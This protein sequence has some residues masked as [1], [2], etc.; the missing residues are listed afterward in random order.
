MKRF[1]LL[2]MATVFVL[3]SCVLP[4]AIALEEEKVISQEEMNVDKQPQNNT[5]SELQSTGSGEGTGESVG[6]GT[7]KSE[8]APAS[9]G[10]SVGEG[11]P[12]SEDAPVSEGEI[13]S[14]KVQPEENV[15]SDLTEAPINEEEQNPDLLLGMPLMGVL[16]EKTYSVEIP[17]INLNSSLTATIRVTVNNFDEGDY[18][19]IDVTSDNGKKLINSKYG[20]DIG[21]DW[22][23]KD[24]LNH[25]TADMETT[26]TFTVGE[27]TSNIVGLEYT[28]SLTFT[29]TPHFDEPV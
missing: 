17:P 8:G 9:E 13:P 5:L 25:I 18:L 7:P 15:D 24:A 10:E 27:Y 4:F 1:F 21:Y 28:D 3:S 26:I 20:Y 23:I 6:E 12:K 19:D 14:E 22:T 16:Q 2:L 29:V 11:T